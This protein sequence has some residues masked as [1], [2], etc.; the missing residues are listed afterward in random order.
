MNEEMLEKIAEEAFVDE[1]EKIGKI[2]PDVLKRIKELEEKELS[3]YNKHIKG[4]FPEIKSKRNMLA[5]ASGVG[6]AGI[7]KLL[8]IAL[9][10]KG[11]IVAPV[12]GGLSG[13]F[14]GASGYVSHAQK[15]NPKYRAALKKGL[16]SALTP[17]ESDEMDTLYD[18][19]PT[20]VWK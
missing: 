9:K 12:L 16:T 15:V 1:L 20:L 6:G 2:N 7:G 17:K 5:L 18:T 8:S 14:A 3:N 4:K 10:G 11:K 19:H 13:A